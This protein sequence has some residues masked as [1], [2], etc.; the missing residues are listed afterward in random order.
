MG[1]LALFDLDHTLLTGDTDVLWCEFLMARGV[2]DRSAF[3]SRNAE[4]ERRY[5]EGSV[6]AAEF[7]GFFVATLAG[8][9]REGWAGLRQAFLREVIVPRIPPQAVA[10]VR[11][12]QAAGDLV[13]MTTATNRFLTELT[14]EHLGIAHLIATE[15]EEDASG[16][17][18]RTHGTL[19]MRE[20][21][22][23][24]LHAWLAQRGQA[25]PDWHSMFYSD[26]RNDLPLL[27]VVREAVA[28][29]PDPHLAAVAAERG[30][31][32]LRLREATPQAMP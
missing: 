9:T 28:V 26:S 8:R 10:L 14:A 23:A 22:V 29:D 17:T 6:S 11:S 16:F 4:M 30:W 31:Q 24:R 5:R 15:C 2:L 1:R 3:E 25:L 7:S 20:G 12:H 21:K 32:V 13:V 27:E 19:N 18:G